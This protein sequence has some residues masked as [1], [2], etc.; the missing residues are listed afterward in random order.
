[1]IDEHLILYEE[2]RSEVNKEF[3]CQCIVNTG[4]NNDSIGKNGISHVIEHFL[5]NYSKR[6]SLFSVDR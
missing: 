2:C 3:V 1:M 5:I 4:S 6:T